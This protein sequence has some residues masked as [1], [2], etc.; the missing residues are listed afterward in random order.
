M[1]FV[2]VIGWVPLHVRTYTPHL[3]ISRID[4]LIVLKFDV[5]MGGGTAGDGVYR[6]PAIFSTFNITPERIDFKWSSSPNRRSLAPPL[7]FGLRPNSDEVCK[8]RRWGDC[9]YA[10]ASPVS[11]SR[12]TLNPFPEIT[13][14]TKLFL[15]RSL[16]VRQTWRIPGWYKI[17]HLVSRCDHN[18]PSWRFCLPH[19]QRTLILF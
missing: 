14:K 13:P 4:W 7:D 10:R 16:V 19:H 15:S 1:R 2:Q 8:N 6:S 9:T 17:A 3:R 5:C 11:L 18:V 12:K